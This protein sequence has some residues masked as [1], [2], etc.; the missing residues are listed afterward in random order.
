MHVQL[1]K[2][3]ELMQQGD[4]ESFA[5]ELN[6]DAARTREWFAQGFTEDGYGVDVIKALGTAG[7]RKM[8]SG[9]GEHAHG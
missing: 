9:E 6:L 1:G 4:A 8:K 2:L 3:R 5:R 7:L